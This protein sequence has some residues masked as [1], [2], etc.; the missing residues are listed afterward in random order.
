MLSK[1]MPIY[2][3]NRLDSTNAF[4]QDRSPSDHAIRGGHTPAFQIRPR[5]RISK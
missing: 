2:N 4:A 3:V 5:R 1:D